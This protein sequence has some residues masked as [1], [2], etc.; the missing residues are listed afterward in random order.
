MKTFNINN[1]LEL[2]ESEDMQY[3]ICAQ[4]E[5]SVVAEIQE[6]TA[7]VPEEADRARRLVECFN[8]FLG[9]E[10]ATEYFEKLKRKADKW[11]ALD[12]KISKCYGEENEEGEWVDNEDDNTD[13]GTIGEIAARAFGFL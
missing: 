10:D 6:A 4:N 5:H 2:L 1:K 8:L 12:E 7:E 3:E 11:D 9:I 13:L